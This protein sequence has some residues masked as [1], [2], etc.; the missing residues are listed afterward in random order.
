VR[1]AVSPHT[2]DTETWQ[3]AAVKKAI[4][5]P[6]PPGGTDIQLLHLSAFHKEGGGAWVGW[7]CASGIRPVGAVW[8]LVLVYV[9]RA[10]DDSRRGMRLLSVAE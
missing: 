7:R 10:Q 2:L 5:T 6:P 1:S 9:S 8:E 4:Y 3:T